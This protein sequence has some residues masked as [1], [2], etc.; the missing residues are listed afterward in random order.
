M[1]DLPLDF[2]S[3]DWQQLPSAGRTGQRGG[4]LYGLSRTTLVE[5]GQAGHIKV[6]AL[7]KPG[8]QKAI[9]LIYMPSLN[10]YLR[11]LAADD[12]AGQPQAVKAPVQAKK[13]RKFP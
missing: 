10:T 2:Q 11:K 8:A 1:V 3:E 12:N 7:R 4:R 13:R 5:L 9:R 6:I